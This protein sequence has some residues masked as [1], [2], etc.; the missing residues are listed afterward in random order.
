M[1]HK[2]IRD[3]KTEKIIE[4]HI[5][6][7]MVRAEL[8]K[9]YLE[10][11][12][13]ASLPGFRPGKV[14]LEVI[15]QRFKKETHEEVMKNLMSDSFNKAMKESGIRILGIPEISDLEFEEEKEMSYKAKVAVRPEVDIKSYKGLELKKFDIEV[16]ESDV[17]AYINNLREM[18][19]KF[20]TRDGK[21][22]NGDYIICDMD[23]FVDGKFIEKKENAWLYVSDDS[24][25][26]G[27]ELES[28]SVNDEKDIEKDLPKEYSKKELAGKRAKF[29][30][31]VKEVKEKLLPELNDEFAFEAAKFNNMAELREAIRENIRQHKK[32]EERHNLEYQAMAILDKSAVFDVPQ[33]VVDKHLDRL[34]EEAK[35][36]LK[37][38]NY[39]ED[40]IKS[41][42]PEIRKR[43]EDEALR[44][45]R[46]YF[47]LDEIAKRE[48]IKV[49]EA[50]LEAAFNDIAVSSGRS[51]E[52]VKKY[53]EENDLVNDLAA[54]IRQGKVFDFI[55]ANAKIK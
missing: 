16:K 28:L 38:E 51:A 50:E 13:A 23:C 44:G 47:L 11:S 41:K 27:K 15:K 2:I 21:A 24:Y 1:K 42:E 7:D 3:N 53:Y 19:A 46:S 32:A 30:I 48:N 12:K 40:D 18:S 43:L 35:A 34:V 39:T 52:E 49:S 37:R 9:A 8:E 5:P 31:K 22:L 33:S 20:K 54:D 36:R 55:V 14:P 25:I 6:K 26:P 4:I 29:H 17:D 45:V 10:I